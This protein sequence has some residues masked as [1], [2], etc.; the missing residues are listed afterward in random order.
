MVDQTTVVL[1]I[2]SSASLYFAHD[3]A[4]SYY[5]A[6]PESIG[7]VGLAISAFAFVGIVLNSIAYEQAMD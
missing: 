6:S 7:S 5:G 4:H 2:V 1:G 3:Y